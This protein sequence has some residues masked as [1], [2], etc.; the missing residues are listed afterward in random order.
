[1]FGRGLKLQ[2]AIMITCQMAFILFGYDQGVFSG[3][4]TNEDWRGTF[5]NPGSGVEGIIV[6]IYNL[7]AFSGCILTFVW[8]EKLGRRLCMWV[9]MGW[10]VRRGGIWVVLVAANYVQIVGAILQCTSY[11]V[12]QIMVA[13]YITG[14][15]TGIET[16]TVPMYQSELCDADKRGRLVSSEPLFVGVGI[17]I[18]YFF[19]YG[20]RYVG[21]PVAWRVPIACQVVFAFLVIILVFGVPESPR[22]LYYRGRNEE[23]LKVM[24]DVWDSPPDGEKVIKMQ[25]EILET[26]ALEKKHGQY[27]WRE[28]FKRDDVQTGRRVLLAY[29]MQFMNQ[30][31]GIN[32]VSRLTGENP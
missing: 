16:S 31:G 29:G 8:G 30:V 32:L 21:G 3:I 20:M 28:I 12:P 11:S 24:C 7:G 1:M 26:I 6:S 5:G 4:V 17:V 9:A 27:K 2:I 18:S 14:I 22:W 25:T 10:I 13:R 19:D 23:A 15:G